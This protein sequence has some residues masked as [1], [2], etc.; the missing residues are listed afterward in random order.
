MLGGAL[1]LIV[2]GVAHWPA[3]AQTAPTHERIATQDY[4]LLVET[5]ASGLRH[6]WSLAFLP[7]GAMLVTER[8]GAIRLVTRDGRVSD[9]L[10]GTPPV[11]AVN[12]A[13]ML[14]IALDP[15]FDENGLVYMAYAEERDG[16]IALSVAR[17]AFDR[18]AGAFA[19]PDVIFRQLPA[20]SGGRH[21]GARLAFHPDGTLFVTAGDRGGYSDES[22]EAGNHIGAIMRIN[23]D[24]SIPAGNPHETMEGWAPEVWSIGHRNVQGATMRP[25]TEQFW[26]HEHGARG[27]DE[28]NLIEPGLN[29]G[30][31]VI[32]YG[33]HY[34]GGEIG[35][36]THK[37]GMEQPVY[38]WDPALAPSGMAF[39]DGD[40]FPQW[41]GDL[42]IGGLVSRVVSRL[43]LSGDSVVAE[44]RILGALG[45]RI[46]DV[47][48]GPDG[49]LYLLSDAENGRI[50]RLVP[51][52]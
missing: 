10:A 7:D 22:Q 31:P 40:A 33:T 15:D 48:N 19:E 34:T 26:T 51:V 38:Y 47:R 12:Q 43:T 36:G 14:D 3:Q 20:V 46:R 25:G 23:P 16:G 30:W 45:E 44:E 24:G 29:Y 49:A 9:P 21:L 6:P 28:V 27:G 18:E 41:Q 37:E 52:P 4:E 13:G 2:G 42:F 1:A 50:L 17:A 11:A 32:A 35:V 5:V 39:Y 8:P